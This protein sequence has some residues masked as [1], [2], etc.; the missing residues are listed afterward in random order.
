MGERRAFFDK[1]TESLIRT[2]RNDIG[3]HFGLAAAI[4]SVKRF[5]ENATGK[6]E[7]FSVGDDVDIRLHFASEVAVTALLRHLEDDDISNFKQILNDTVVEG[8]RH[9]ARC[10]QVLCGIWVW[11][12]FGR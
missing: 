2:I 6:M 1:E 7:L 8:Y 10:V 5:G 12:R 11:Q 9:A 4:E 3:G